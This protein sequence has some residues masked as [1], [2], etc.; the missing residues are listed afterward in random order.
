MADIVVDTQIAV[1]YFESSTR[2]S[3]LADSR[4]EEAVRNGG[5]IF[6]SSITIVEKI[7][8][9]EKG[10]LSQP[11]LERLL[12]ELQMADSSF[13]TQSLTADIARS[14]AD[15]PRATVPDM[16]DRIIAATA[17]HLSLPLITSDDN[18]QNLTNVE[19]IW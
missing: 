16:P 7:Y 17:L 9:V 14:L 5:T 2:L 10:R 1:W 6:I 12:D 8:L 19:T 3:K 4:L 11:M 13:R 18:I 15:I